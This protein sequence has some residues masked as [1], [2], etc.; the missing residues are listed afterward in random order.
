MRRRYRFGPI[1]R[2]LVFGP[3]DA[4]QAA[5][6]GGGAVL[7]MVAFVAL[8]GA[9]GLAS[10]FVVLG[11]ALTGISVPIEGRTAQEWAPATFGWWRRRL[12]GSLRYRSSA[13]GTGTRFQG[14]RDPSHDLSLPAE[15]SGLELLSVPYGDSEVGMMRDAKAGTYTIAMAVRGGAFIMRDADEQERALD[16]Y[17]E[18]LASTA[19]DGS[20]VRRIQWIQQTT[21]ASGD[22]LLAHFER[23]RDRAVPFDSGPYRSYVELLEGAEPASTEY[24]TLVAVQISERLGARELRRLGGGV[25][26]AGDLAVREAESL[27]DRLD[28]AGVRVLGLLRPRQYAAHLRDAYDPFGRAGRERLAV[29]DR[30]REGVEPALMGPMASEES[31]SH[32]RTD[33]AWHTTWWISSWPRSEV[34]PMF[35]VPLLMGSG[36]M[37]TVAVTIEPV[38]YS[39]A[40][41]RAEAAQTAEIAEQMQRSRQGYVTTAR[42]RRRADAVSRRE[43][44]LA[45]GHA[46]VHVGGWVRVYRH[47]LEELEQAE[48]PTEHAAALAR[49]GL[50]RAYGEQAAAF[51]NTLLLAGGL[52]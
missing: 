44:E 47:D 36:S 49:L 17:G 41:R 13:P 24:D 9:P 5:T 6:L 18:V 38:P 34:G 22:D 48:G 8:G 51:A 23:H 32:Y 28:L 50:Q 7:A 11:A 35:M 45:D 43:E 4:P 16:A 29:A 12:E 21:P 31:W 46:L 1:E 10:G 19:R 14:D 42:T 2:R 15:L 40:M 20:P 25:E 3:L 27:A 30:T 33:S 39:Q 52:G 37:R 26:A